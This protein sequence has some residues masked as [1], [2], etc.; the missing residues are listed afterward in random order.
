MTTIAT[1][2]KSM[3]GDG[4]REMCRTIVDTKAQKVRRLADGRIVGTSGDTALGLQVVEWLEGKAPKPDRKVDDF[5]AIILYPSGKVETLS[6][7]FQPIE[8]EVPVAVGSGMDFAI[9][10]MEAGKEPEEAV[11]IACKRDPGSGGK[12]IVLRASLRV[13]A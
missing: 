6:D 13:A 9:G 2:G 8:V 11:A 3:A 4:L 5:A 1:D 10:A 7:C 12:I